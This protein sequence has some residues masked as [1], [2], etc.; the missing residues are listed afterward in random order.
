MS[1]DAGTNGVYTDSKDVPESLWEWIFARKEKV[2]Q[3]QKNRRG[4]R[5][6]E[7]AE[8]VNQV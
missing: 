6:A 3:R 1:G 7:G 4:S 5:R 2:A 8:Q